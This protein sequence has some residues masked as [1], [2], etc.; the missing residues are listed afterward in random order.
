MWRAGGWEVGGSHPCPRLPH[1]GTP[2]GLALGGLGFESHMGGGP[3]RQSRVRGTWQHCRDS[4]L[5]G[6]QEPCSFPQN[7]QLNC[8]GN[9]AASSTPAPWAPLAAPPRAF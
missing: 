9:I 2:C 7:Q 3:G 4:G 5:R 1:L 8:R 6:R